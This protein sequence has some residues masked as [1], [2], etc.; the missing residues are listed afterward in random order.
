MKYFKFEFK[1][2]LIKKKYDSCIIFFFFT[3]L[4][5]PYPDIKGSKCN[6]HPQKKKKKIKLKNCME[7]LLLGIKPFCYFC[8]TEQKC[9]FF[10]LAWKSTL[11]LRIVITHDY[12]LFFLLW[13][14]MK[15][16]MARKIN[17]RYIYVIT[18]YKTIYNKRI[19]F[20]H[21]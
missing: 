19:G 1:N 2:V 9:F 3:I 5:F 4:F 7:I 16:V 10:V 15:S 18:F 17:L 14:S 21:F 20:G 11:I 13:L 12:K 6:I 8:I